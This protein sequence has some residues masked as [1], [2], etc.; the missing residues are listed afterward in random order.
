MRILHV[1]TWLRHGGVETWLLDMIERLA[2]ER[3]ISDVCCKG[4]DLGDPS[5]VERAKACGASLFHCPL[6]PAVIGFTRRLRFILGSGRYDIVHNHLELYSGIPV[7]VAR[8]MGIPIITSFHNTAFAP[9]TWTR[10][11]GFRQARDLFGKISVY[12]ALKH[13]N[14]ITGCSG[15]VL[16]RLNREYHLDPRFRVLYYG[17]RLPAPL[18]EAEREMFRKE[19]RKEMGWEEDTAII[20]H[21]GRFV[22][23]KNQKGVICVFKRVLSAFPKAR[24]ILVGSPQTYCFGS[25]RHLVETLGLGGYVRFLGTRNDVKRLMI[26]SDVLL[27]PSLFEGFGLVAIEASSVGL[28]VVASR[29]PGLTEAVKDG[30]TGLLFGVEDTNGM[31]QAVVR[32]ISDR[33]YSQHMGERARSY[34]QEQFSLEASARRLLELYHECLSLS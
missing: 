1:L 10:F 22:E 13:S 8:R 18:S 28:P 30:E 24:L 23:Q 32:L 3:H 2:M 34:V 26:A 33:M 16:A 14:Y 19:V 17:V 29:V 4:P 12:Y 5:L 6:N 20:L 21:V 31:A 9:Q 25:V 27:F 7:W 15:A 11:P